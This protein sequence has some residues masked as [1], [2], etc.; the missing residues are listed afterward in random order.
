M[1]PEQIR[2]ESRAVGS[3]TDV[4]A[5][6]V[7]LYEL[8]TRRKPFEGP[9]EAAF[10]TQICAEDPIRPRRL[11]RDLPGGLETVCLKCLEKNPGDRYRSPSELANDLQRVLEDVDPLGR[12]SPL[13]KRSVRQVERQPVRAALLGMTTL[14][15]V[16]I[17]E[18]VYHRW[19]GD[20][21][22][23]IGQ[24][25]SARIIDLPDLVP[26]LSARDSNVANRLRSLFV[27]GNDSEKLAVALVLAK[28]FP[29]YSD[30]CYGRLLEAKPEE[31]AIIARVLND[32][33]SKLVL[34]L[35]AEVDGAPPPAK[36]DKEQADRHRA[37]AAC[38]LMLLGSDERPWSLLRFT[39]DP[40]ART[41]LIHSLGRAGVAPSRVFDRLRDPATD[42]SVRI[43][44]IQSLGLVPDSKWDDYLRTGVK[45]WLLDRYRNDPSAG[46]HGS[47]KWLLRRW[48][49]RV[50]LE[51]IDGE[52]AG[53]SP[54]DPG[55]QWRIS[56]EGLTL[57][58][59]DDPALDRVIEVS[60]TEITVEMFER[61][62]QTRPKDQQSYSNPVISPDDSCPV[63]G[64]SYYDAAAFCNWLSSQERCSEDEASYRFTG[65][66][67]VDE[68]DEKH[69]IYEP[70]DRHRDRG[71]FRLPTNQEFDVCCS[72]GTSTRR[73]H[74]DSNSLFDWYA[75]TRMNTDGST[76][77]VASLIPNEIGLFDTLGN[78]VE[79]CDSRDQRG[80]WSSH[81]RYTALD[82]STG[83]KEVKGYHREPSQGF[84]V[85]RTKKVR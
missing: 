37:N 36:G 17:A 56:H 81:G 10:L 60:D 39:P 63:N 82:K 29:D 40:Q 25:V 73:Y 85:V 44:L 51:R 35:R 75:A 34:Q 3:T 8:L 21:D 49:A 19:R 24:L 30:Y 33:R 74:G 9:N 43:A 65:K 7:I 4:W 5:L 23:R 12:R 61:F 38:A 26:R 69:M 27:N 2:C 71:G 6:G 48:R 50:E 45:R 1:A 54:P 47:T 13:W 77:P 70:G 80:G 22:L 16:I 59:L 28:E 84:R 66:Y 18:Y 72:A 31:L 46:I 55:F 14:A 83:F 78:V 57:I 42:P 32:Q 53:A 68:E 15:V 62:D 52:L 58:T 76:L 79:W 64:T 11:R 20:T 41:F 67:D